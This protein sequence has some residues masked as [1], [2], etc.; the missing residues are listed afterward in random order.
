MNVILVSDEMLS[1]LRTMAKQLE[2]QGYRTF[3]ETLRYLT[4]KAISVDSQMSFEDF[5]SLIGE[6][7]TSPSA[8]PEGTWPLRND[9]ED[10][11]YDDDPNP[12]HGTYSE[13]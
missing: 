9:V 13:D 6:R 8:A 4:E 7:Q 5:D 12:Y 2:T 11:R 1:N 3:P 10:G